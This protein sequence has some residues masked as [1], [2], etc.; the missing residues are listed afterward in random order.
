MHDIYAFFDIMHVKLAN[1]H[2]ICFDHCELLKIDVDWERHPQLIRIHWRNRRQSTT[3]IYVHTGFSKSGRP[4]SKSR[5]PTNNNKNPKHR[6]ILTNS[7]TI[8]EHDHPID[9]LHRKYLWWRCHFFSFDFIVVV[10]LTQ[11]TN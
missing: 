11:C 8:G 3:Q 6:S 1:N 4:I 7:D 5:S 10:V 2:L 9:A